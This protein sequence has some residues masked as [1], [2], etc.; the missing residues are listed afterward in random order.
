MHIVYGVVYQGRCFLL[1]TI[2][3]KFSGFIDLNR[4]AS[5]LLAY[6]IF[7]IPTFQN[8]FKVAEHFFA[9]GQR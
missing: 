2:F 9:G 5:S 4:I 6:S 7:Y 3:Q 8:T 1:T